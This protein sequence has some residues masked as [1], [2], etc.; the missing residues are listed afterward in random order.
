MIQIISKHKAKLIINIGSGANRRRRTRTVEYSG[1][2]DLKKKHD[3]FEA[4]VRAV[5]NDGMTVGALIRTYIESK[6]LLGAKATTIRGYRAV[7][8]R[9]NSRFERVLASSLTT[10]QIDDYVAQMSKNGLSPKSVANTI[11]LLNSAYARAVRS[12]QLA[13]NP[14]LYVELPKRKKPEILTFSDEEVAR[15]WN[16]LA[17]ERL[18]YKVAYGL[19]LFCGLRRSEVLGLRET[20]I[21]FSLRCATVHSTRHR[22]TGE[23][24]VIQDT[25]TD[26][27]RRTIAVPD[28]LLQ[29]IES[30]VKEHHASA[31]NSTDYLIQNGF[32]E[33]MSPSTLTKY[34]AKI[35]SKA[36]LPRVSV[37]GLRHTF[38]TMLNATGVDIARIS[39]ELGHSAIGT[40]LNIYTH[41]FGSA[42]ASS[43]GIADAI[44]GKI[45]KTATFPP[46]EENKKPCND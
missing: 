6:E 31:Y 21:D 12:G 11:S 43:R 39:A 40:T 1:K 42:S 41:V 8:K 19:C 4:E 14:C 2:R 38:A 18:D 26:K 29:E 15:F 35:E 23:A 27:S 34:I 24:D 7:E 9:L 20:D 45:T 3:L 36:S 28:A 25:K 32:G 46:L 17:N 16:A 44:N 33:P 10:Y 37:H 5:V 30:L 22:I 13:S